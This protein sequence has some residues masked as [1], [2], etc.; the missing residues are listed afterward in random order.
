VL[1]QTFTDWELVV[2]DNHSTDNTEQII[3]GFKDAR[4]R[5]VRF[6]NHGVI[7]ASRNY[8]ITLA[9]APIIAFLDSDDWWAPD[10]LERCMPLF[11]TGADVVYHTLWIVKD[12]QQK[13]TQ[14][15]DIR[16]LKQPVYTDL[17]SRGNTI[18][19]SG[20]MVRKTLLEQ[21]G[22]FSEE[23]DLIAWEDFDCWLRIARLTDNFSSVAVPLGYYWVGGDNISSAPR[24]LD[25]LAAMKKHYFADQPAKLPFWY[26]DRKALAY[27]LLKQHFLAYQNKLRALFRAPDIGFKWR[28]SKVLLKWVLRIS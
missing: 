9:Q 7:A 3:A 4:L 15:I 12:L 28:I 27:H 16:A 1:D 18:P 10:K 14:S 11:A 5:F 22:G 24:M 8:G 20:T 26:Y 2:V 6:H 21:V 23:K 19:T 17:L 25:N 13:P